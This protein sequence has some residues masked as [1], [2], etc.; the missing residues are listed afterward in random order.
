[1]SLFLYCSIAPEFIVRLHLIAVASRVCMSLLSSDEP[2]MEM[3]TVSVLFG[4]RKCQYLGEGGPYTGAALLENNEASANWRTANWRTFTLT[5]ARL[6]SQSRYS[7][8]DL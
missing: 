8:L 2:Q 5:L 1:M 6:S 7:M 4:Y 3:C